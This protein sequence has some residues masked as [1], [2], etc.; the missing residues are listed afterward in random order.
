MCAFALDSTFIFYSKVCFNLPSSFIVPYILNSCFKLDIWSK[1]PC[2][3]VYS[4]A[5]HNLSSGFP[6]AFIFLVVKLVCKFAQVSSLFD[7]SL[8]CTFLPKL[9]NDNHSS[10]NRRLFGLVGG[11]SDYIWSGH[12][13]LVAIATTYLW[14]ESSLKKQIGLLMYNML[15][16]ILIIATRNHYTVDVYL[17]WIIG[18]L[19]GC[20]K[21]KRT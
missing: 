21:F 11:E 3:F 20:V 1:Y 17:A 9:P 8:Y 6:A 12:A 13:S 14:K 18:G 15:L 10:L 16:G 5:N 2:K 4:L 19:L 7:I